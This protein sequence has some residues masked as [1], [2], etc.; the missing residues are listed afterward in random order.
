MGLNSGK[1]IGIRRGEDFVCEK[2]N[3]YSLTDRECQ[4]NLQRTQQRPQELRCMT[5]CSLL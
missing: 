3:I 4:I 1:I 2:K 5:A